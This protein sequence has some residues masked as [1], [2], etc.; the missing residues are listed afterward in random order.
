MLERFTCRVRKTTGLCIVLL[1][2]L[3]LVSCQ[4]PVP[5]PKELN[6]AEL[7]AA[8]LQ[9]L[10]FPTMLEIAP[11]RLQRYYPYDDSVFSVAYVHLAFDVVADEIALFQVEETQKIA[12]IKAGLNQHYSERAE[13]FSSY[14]PEESARIQ[15]RLTI[16]HDRWIIVVITDDTNAAKDIVNAHIEG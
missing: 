1:L 12:D 9:D 15:N 13:V 10:G 6:P 14:A 16:E 3:V 5:E 11:E 2:A 7:S 8:L 4:A